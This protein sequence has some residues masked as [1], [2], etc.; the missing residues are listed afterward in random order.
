MNSHHCRLLLSYHRGSR[1]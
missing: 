1:S